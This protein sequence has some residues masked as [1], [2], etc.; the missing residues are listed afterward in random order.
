M[1]VTDSDTQEIKTILKYPGAKNRIADWIV[2]FI[3]EHKVYLEPFFGGG[4]VF[5]HKQKSRI[6]TINDLDNNVY[7]FFKVLRDKPEELIWRLWKA[8]SAG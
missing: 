5:F 6:E 3:P 1:N 8:C 7:T 4:A 2:S